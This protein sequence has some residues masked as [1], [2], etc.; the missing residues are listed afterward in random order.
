MSK[1]TILV[2]PDTRQLLKRMGRKE[3][4][5][6]DLLKEMIARIDRCAKCEEC[7]DNERK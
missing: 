5:Y 7:G 4:T 2:E 1:T 6:D 3:Q